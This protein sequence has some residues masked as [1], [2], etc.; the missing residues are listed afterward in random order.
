[1]ENQQYEVQSCQQHPCDTNI[2]RKEGTEAVETKKTEN[3]E[4][5][6]NTQELSRH[7]SAWF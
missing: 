6:E 2:P 3:T 7:F 5:I 4:N 1:M